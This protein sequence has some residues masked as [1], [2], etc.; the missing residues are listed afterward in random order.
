MKLPI[1]DAV[2]KSRLLGYLSYD[3][4]LHGVTL[5]ARMATEIRP[6]AMFATS[7]VYNRA[8]HLASSVIVF[9]LDVKQESKSEVI[10]EATRKI[11]T[12]ERKVLLTKETL[13]TLMKM[14]RFTLPGET[15]RDAAGRWRRSANLY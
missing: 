2:N 14:D 8:M 12:V 5:N 7:E 1:Y 11:I 15:S 10:N 13:E 6:G 9:D 4:P 3:G